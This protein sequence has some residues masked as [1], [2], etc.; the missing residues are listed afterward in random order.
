MLHGECRFGD[1]SEVVWFISAYTNAATKSTRWCSCAAANQDLP[2]DEDEIRQDLLHGL[3]VR[4]NPKIDLGA[5]ESRRT[6]RP[7]PGVRLSNPWNP[8]TPKI[9][10]AKRQGLRHGTPRSTDA[11]IPGPE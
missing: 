7:V 2:V 4:L 9:Y 8:E 5:P 11:E 10:A 1:A 6:P 3:Q